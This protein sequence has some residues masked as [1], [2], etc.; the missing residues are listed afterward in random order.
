M[1]SYAFYSTDVDNSG[2]AAVTLLAV[3]ILAWRDGCT[4]CNYVL[5]AEYFY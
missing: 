1:D 2:M 3:G 5:T 4:Y